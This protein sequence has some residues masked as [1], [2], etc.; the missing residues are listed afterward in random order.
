MPSQQAI[1]VTRV[2]HQLWPSQQIGFHPNLD[3]ETQQQLRDMGYQ[4]EAR[5]FFGDM[6]VIKRQADGNLEAA[7]DQRGRGESRVWPQPQ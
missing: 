2:H 4:V 5:R 1:D 7:S 3:E 6:Q